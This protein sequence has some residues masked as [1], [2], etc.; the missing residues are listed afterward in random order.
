MIIDTDYIEIPANTKKGI[1]F[2]VTAPETLEPGT[3]YNLIVLEPTGQDD[4]E[5]PVIG[6]SGALSH[7]VKLHLTDNVKGVQAT[8]K[9]DTTLEVLDR[10]IP[11]I[12]PAKIKFTFFN[13][14]K[15]SLTPKGEIQVVKRSGDQEPQYYKINSSGDKVFPEQSYEEDYEIEKWYL[16]DIFF[17]KNA[18]M[19]VQN[20]IDENVRSEEVKIPGFRNEFLYII[21]TITVVILLATSLKGDTK[22]EQEYAE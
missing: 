14:S 21:A 8:D 12:K 15:Y 11:F 9:Y 10:G 3:Y 18:Y 19:R 22:P 7:L 6:A 13:N 1:T 17:G 20:G 2:I 5:K 4:E 16:E